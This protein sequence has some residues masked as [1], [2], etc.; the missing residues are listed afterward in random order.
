MV[1]AACQY[2]YRHAAYDISRRIEFANAWKIRDRQTNPAFERYG[3]FGYEA[4]AAAADIDGYRFLWIPQ[5]SS[6]VRQSHAGRQGGG[7]AYEAS[8]LL[9]AFQQIWFVDIP[10]GAGIRIAALKDGLKAIDTLSGGYADIQRISALQYRWTG[11]GRQQ[12][13]DCQKGGLD[14]SDGSSVFCQVEIP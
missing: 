4:K 1:N 5:S 2:T 11:A 6:T 9:L 13:L 10:N 7:N 14:F 8:L 3:F 12:E